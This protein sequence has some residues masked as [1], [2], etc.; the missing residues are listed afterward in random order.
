MNI[1]IDDLKMMIA[2]M[3]IQ[4]VALNRIIAQQQAQ[5]TALTPKAGPAEPAKTA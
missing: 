2:E 4:I 5:I 1:T 3:H